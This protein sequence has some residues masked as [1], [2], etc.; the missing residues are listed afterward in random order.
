MI[1][2]NG[3]Q[4]DALLSQ[5]IAN[6]LIENNQPLDPIMSSGYI[7]SAGDQL[8]YTYLNLVKGEG[9]D[10]KSYSRDM[11]MVY[12]AK[13][14]N[15]SKIRS[16]AFLGFLDPILIGSI[17]SA[18]YGENIE[19]PKL[20]IAENLAIT[21]FAGMNITPYGILEKKIGTYI[22]TDYTPVKIAF[23]F[24]KQNKSRTA[25][26]IN[27]NERYRLSYY[28]RQGYMSSYSD[29]GIWDN[30]VPSENKV[31]NYN[32]YLLEFRVYNLLSFDKVKLSANGAIWSQPEILT[33]D[34]YNAKAKKGWM[35]N[36]GADYMLFDNLALT[37]KAG[38]KKK[39]FVAGEIVKSGATVSLGA[40]IK[41]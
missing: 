20:N 1:S 10:L 18:I 11:E 2:L 17:Y 19:I 9:H 14:M 29:S 3:I 39:G 38:Y 22:F 33:K 32:S 35:I 24:G 37:M 26:K 16:V 23:S 5:K 28:R 41:L 30:S 4:S 6:N 15:M 13:S 31:K 12:G 7:F 21:P 8:I 36:L 27:Q 40:Q 34:S 25:A